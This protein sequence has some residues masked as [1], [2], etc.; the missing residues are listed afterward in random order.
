MTDCVLLQSGHRG[1]DH[2]DSVEVRLAAAREG[3]SRERARLER[4]LHQA[5]AE[6][7]RLRGKIRADSLWDFSDHDAD[8]AALKVVNFYKIILTQSFCI[9][10]S[11]VFV[12]TIYE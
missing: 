3:W 10:T 7:A 2:R 12:C 6:V 11:D 4:S 9:M 1:A 5:E 8:S